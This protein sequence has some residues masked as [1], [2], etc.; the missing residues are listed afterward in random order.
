MKGE[1]QEH[2]N[3]ETP[4]DVRIKEGDHLFFSENEEK[5][6]DI[7]I[8]SNYEII[9]VNWIDTPNWTIHPFFSEVVKQATLLRTA[10]QD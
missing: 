5:S 6:Y 2:K 4:Y 1:E 7:N 10:V 8:S 9:S 3:Q